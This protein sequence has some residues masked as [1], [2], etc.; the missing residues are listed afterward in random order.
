[1]ISG[2]VLTAVLL[3]GTVLGYNVA[4][5]T[6]TGASLKTKLLIDPIVM[7]TKRNY[8]EDPYVVPY[9]SIHQLFSQRYN[10]TDLSFTLR[11][12][13]IRN[14]MTQAAELGENASIL[15]EAIKVIYGQYWTMT[16]YIIPCY[17]EKA[18]YNNESVWVLAF[19]CVHT[20]SEKQLSHFA[21]F[22]VSISTLEAHM[23]TGCN[24]SAIVFSTSCY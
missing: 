13:I 8:T 2:L 20:L 21:L 9:R 24:A 7:I 23:I 22:F 4:L 11:D 6:N 10:G 1:M 5:L 16:P 18:V 14:M 3:C 15:L 19:N 12:E 17:A